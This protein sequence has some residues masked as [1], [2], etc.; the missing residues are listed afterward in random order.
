MNT[1]YWEHVKP[2]LTV[3]AAKVDSH[4][5]LARLLTYKQ[6]RRIVGQYTRTYP[7][8]FQHFIYMLLHNIQFIRAK[9]VLLMAWGWCVFVNKVNGMVKRTMWS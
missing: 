6:Y 3:E 8:L 9:L 2:G 4:T 7:A 5:Q 1:W